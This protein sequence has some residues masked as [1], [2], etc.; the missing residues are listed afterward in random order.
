V[1]GYTGRVAAI[2][3]S[4]TDASLYYVGGADGGVWKT[5]N[6]GVSWTPLTDRQPTTSVGALALDPSNDQVLYVGTGEANFAN[7]SR[8]GIGLLK[9]TDGGQSF[10][11]L[12]EA[13]F[14]G[15]CFARLRVHPQNPAL[16]FAAITTAG[17]FPALSAARNHP[18]AKGPVGVFRSTDAGQTWTQLSGGLPVTVSATDLALD[19]TNPLVVYAAIGHIFGDARNGIYKSSDGGQT[20]AKL[21]GGLPAL[22]GRITLALAPTNAQ[23]LYASVVNPCDLAGNNG[24]SLDVFRSDNGG[25]SWTAQ[26]VPSY[27]ATYGWYLCTSL[28]GLTDQNL[29]FA[30][31]YT[32]Q[33]TLAGGGTWSA[34]TPPHVDLHALEWDASGRLLCGCDGGIYRS[35]NNGGSWVGLNA[36]LG[37]I[38]FYAGVSLTPGSTTALLGGMQDN[39]SAVRQAGLA[40]TQVLG[41]D[42]GCTAIDFQTGAR[43][44]AEVQ[45]VGTISRSVNGGAWTSSGAGITGRT[46][47]LAPFEIH[48]QNPLAMIYGTE[49]VW[50]S[51]D[52]GVSWATIGPD[53]TQGGSAAIRGLGWAPS[54]PLVIYASTNDGNVQVTTNGGSSWQPRLANVPGWPRT[55]RPFAIHPGDPRRCWLAVGAFATDQVLAT[56]DAFATVRAIDGD[57]PDVPVHCVAVDTR[58]AERVAIYLGTERGVWRGLS[59]GSHWEPYGAGLPNAPVVD[60][61]VDFVNQ[62]LVAATQGRGA[63]EAALVGRNQ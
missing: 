37:L 25:A 60:L 7:H 56:D 5:T 63:W 13:T 62:R 52:G 14:A 38:Q 28:V 58:E 40:W 31:G 6:A 20:F 46:C 55:T 41:G 21:G 26:A 27:Q 16:L 48:A 4:P 17:G 22:P 19:P 53:L 18:L 44:F 9:S 15:R 29:F 32:L 12:A 10:A 54:D 47:F 33:R 57:L 34:V 61:R 59:T 51:A 8:Y 3:P 30:G 42:G 45:G 39:G 24:G 23:R 50:R 36:G 2:A 1:N 35:T 43:R 11:L 49:R